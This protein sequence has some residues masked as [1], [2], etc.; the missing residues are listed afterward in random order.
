MKFYVHEYYATILH[1][2]LLISLQIKASC[3]LAQTEYI[4]L[5]R[6]GTHKPFS[7]SISLAIR[8]KTAVQD[9]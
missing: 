4:A 5:V 8:F 7:E 9:I 3:D 1:N 2:F 6:Q